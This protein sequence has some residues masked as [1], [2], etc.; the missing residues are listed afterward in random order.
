MKI[1]QTEFSLQKQN[2]KTENPESLKKASKDFE[3]LIISEMMKVF[4]QSIP[5]DGL[6]SGG[7]GEEIFTSML[8]SELSKKISERGSFGVSNIVEKQLSG[9]VKGG[10][11]NFM[12]RVQQYSESLNSPL[13]GDITSKFGMRKHPV[14]GDLRMHEG[15][16]IR[17]NEGTPI[18][19]AQNGEVTFSGESDG[20]GNLIII[21]NGDLE[22]RYAH[23][24]ELSVKK[25][26]Q[27]KQGD[28]IG[29]VGNTGTSTGA[30]L[31]F[32]V[33][34]KGV[35]IDPSMLLKRR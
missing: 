31:H 22:T 30:H 12:G 18:K 32:E 34:I 24:S 28:N 33:R 35:A 14:Y 20:Y 2:S 25:G 4:R 13:D 19:S 10:D 26:D 23:C 7:F 1:E 16:D 21:K 11:N 3:S 27:V 15:V 8:D 5:K 29:L 17:A 9:Y 6:T